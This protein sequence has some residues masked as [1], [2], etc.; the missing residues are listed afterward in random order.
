M[1]H[2]TLDLPDDVHDF[3]ERIARFRGESTEQVLVRLLRSA[4]R[5]E[6]AADD[7]GDTPSVEDDPGGHHRLTHDLRGHR[8]GRGW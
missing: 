3:A 8:G 7:D 5:R 2:I 6:L 4:A 1:T